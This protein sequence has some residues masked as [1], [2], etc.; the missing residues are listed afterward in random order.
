LS[1][2]TLAQVE[3]AYQG[4]VAAGIPEVGG[5][6]VDHLWQ[7]ASS[8]PTMGLAGVVLVGAA[9]AERA[10]RLLAASIDESRA[11]GRIRQALEL[12][13]DAAPADVAVAVEQLVADDAP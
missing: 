11:L 13:E 9:Y 10:M 6:T 4:L 1:R 5:Q 8:E 3:A 12:E 7:V 2:P